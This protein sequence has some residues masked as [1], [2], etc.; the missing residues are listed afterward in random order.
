M[1][2]SRL[3]WTASLGVSNISHLATTR[4]AEGHPH[5]CASLFNMPHAISPGSSSAA[6]GDVVMADGPPSTTDADASID[7]APTSA[8]AAQ[9]EHDLDAMFDDDEDDEFAASSAQDSSAP[10]PM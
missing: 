4:A 2:E 1:L 8:Q 5:L 10:A 7:D 9:K 3:S 6:D